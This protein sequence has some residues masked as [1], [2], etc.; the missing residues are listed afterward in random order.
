MHEVLRRTPDVVTPTLVSTLNSPDFN[1]GDFTALDFY[2][3]P[4]ISPTSMPDLVM[5]QGVIL[6]QAWAPVHELPQECDLT[7][8]RIKRLLRN[9]EIRLKDS[10]DWKTETIRTA[11]INSVKSLVGYACPGGH[12]SFTF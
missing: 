6:A 8:E 3:G 2:S 10:E 1:S 5:A 9:A 4:A 7:D 11:S 12:P